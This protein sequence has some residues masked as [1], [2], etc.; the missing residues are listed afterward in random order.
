MTGRIGRS[1]HV[2]PAFLQSRRRMP[3]STRISRRRFLKTAAAA[4]A[5]ST[6][7]LSIPKRVLGANE[8]LNIAGIGANGQAKSDLSN[9]KHEN[10]IALAD[11]DEKRLAEG[12]AELS[13]NAKTFADYREML[14]KLD[15]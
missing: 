7:W 9:L 4:T 10:I 15:K 2:F 12:V 14:D 11:I 13:P 5:A 6:A 8:R 1:I 3:M